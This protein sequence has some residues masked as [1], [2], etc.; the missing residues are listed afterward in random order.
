MR[1]AFCLS[2]ITKI[3]GAERRLTR[4]FDEVGKNTNIEFTLVLIGYDNVEDVLKTYNRFIKHKV[5]IKIMS[6]GYFPLYYYTKESKFDVVCYIGPY[7]AMMPFVFGAKRSGSKCLWLL[8]NTFYSNLLFDNLGQKILFRLTSKLSDHIDCLYPSCVNRIHDI[9]GKPVTATPCSF[10][11]LELFHPEEKTKTIVFLCRLTKG[12]N[13][14]L[15]IQAIHKCEK[16]LVNNGYN[17]VIAGDGEERESLETMTKE[18]NLSDVVKFVGFVNS[19]NILPEC[20]VFVS[21]QDNNNYPSQ[22]LIEAISCGCYIV[23]TEVGETNLIVKSDFGKTCSFSADDISSAI[24]DYLS[25]DYSKREDIIL[26][27]REFALKTFTIEKSVEHYN[28]LFFQ[29]GNHK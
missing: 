19:E 3:G 10:T 16:Q 24:C 28:E 4:L 12:K 22:S 2:G 27:A 6:E 9:T 7:R 25:F 17:V 20:S 8:V 1:V 29:L 15:F 21:L 23:A 14:S 13:C 5:D 11:D 18:L 26:N